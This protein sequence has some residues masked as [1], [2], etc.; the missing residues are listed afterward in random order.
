M[1]MYLTSR[2]LPLALVTMGFSGVDLLFR[3]KTPGDP[4]SYTNI[5]VALLAVFMLLDIIYRARFRFTS[6]I[7]ISFVLLVIGFLASVMSG[8]SPIVGGIAAIRGFVL[9]FA[10]HQEVRS[11]NGW[12]KLRKDILL[13]SLIVAFSI[14]VQEV[15]FLQTGGLVW[16]VQYSTTYVFVDEK[17]LFL[18]ASGF[19][20]D[21]NTAALYPIAG[22]VSLGAIGG[23]KLRMIGT[24]I[25]WAALILTFS[26]G[27]IAAVVMMQFAHLLMSLIGKDRDKIYALGPFITACIAA[28]AGGLVYVYRANETRWAE[29]ISTGRY[30]IWSE[31]FDFLSQHLFLGGGFG[32]F[33]ALGVASH[34][35]PFEVLLNT[36]LVGFGLFSAMLIPTLSRREIRYP[37]Y[38]PQWAHELLI[39]LLFASLFLSTF[40]NL[41]LW[42]AI[43]SATNAVPIAGP[44]RS[45]RVRSQDSWSR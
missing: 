35:L 36:G 16:G 7:A 11:A 26:R 31:A 20:N 40:T 29:D 21:P 12:E 39:T 1:E 45:A 3:G 44:E 6:A 13:S 15:I 41:M 4:W 9:L 17:P 25:L 5:G 14:I 33:Q 38:R 19:V 23:K 10:I 42:V 2:L 28:L 37:L 18:R 34:S 27:G 22:L 24:A 32:A 30:T 8:Y 43:G